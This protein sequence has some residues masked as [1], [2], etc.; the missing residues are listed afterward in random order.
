MPMKLHIVLFSELLLNNGGCESWLYKFLLS[1]SSLFSFYDQIHVYGISLNHSIADDR[2][3]D[4]I[5]DNNVFFHY[6]D[7]TDLGVL[8]RIISF[9]RQQWSY[10]IKYCNAGDHLLSIG[11]FYELF[12]IYFFNKKKNLKKIVWLRTLLEA[13]LKSRKARYILSLICKLEGFCLRHV[14]RIIANGDDT[15]E[16]YEKRYGLKNLVTIPNAI[17]SKTVQKNEKPLENRKI[18]IGFVGR[19]YKAKGFDKFL[20]SIDFFNKDP[21]DSVE[22]III[23]AGDMDD[24]ASRFAKQ[25]K[26]VTFYGAIANDKIYDYLAIL[27]ATVHLTFSNAGGGVSNS[28]L[29]SLFAGNLLVCWNNTIFSQVVNQTSAIMISE[30]NTISL[31]DAYRFIAKNQEVCKVMIR[32]ASRLKEQYDFSHHMGAFLCVI[33]TLE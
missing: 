14:D 22:F 16:F 5:T 19:L 20:E 17:I 31:A 18:K 30:G 32:N 24:D 11:S 7:L 12:A 6:A 29:E 13:H 28:L 8:F 3:A 10:F 25:Y 26:N 23:G 33:K 21:I 4:K 2:I 1:S 15:K 27:D 9:F